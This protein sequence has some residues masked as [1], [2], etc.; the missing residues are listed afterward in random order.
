MLA[1]LQAFRKRGATF[2]VETFFPARGIGGT[3]PKAGD[4]RIPYLKYLSSFP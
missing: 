1:G 3:H 2:S 4:N